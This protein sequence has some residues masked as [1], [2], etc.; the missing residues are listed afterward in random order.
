MSDRPSGGA[1]IARST[2]DALDA[3]SMTID[4]ADA[5]ARL[6]VET[7]TLDNWRWSGRGPA[8]VKVGRLV[9]YRLSDL[10]DWLDQQTRTSTSDPGSH[11]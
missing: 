2:L 3:R 11:A 6:G 8:F 10:A 9:R 1:V 4:T 7:A 5:A